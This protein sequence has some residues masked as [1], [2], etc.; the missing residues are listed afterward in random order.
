M[1]DEKKS[2]RCQRIIR[3]NRD[4]T[5][6]TFKNVVSYETGKIVLGACVF[7]CYIKADG[8]REGFWTFFYYAFPLS[9]LVCNIEIPQKATE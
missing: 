5:F 8:S 4:I 6:T 7:L 1:I 2:Y 9:S 3:R